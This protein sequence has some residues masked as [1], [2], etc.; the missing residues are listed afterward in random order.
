MTTSPYA[1]YKQ[2][3]PVKFSQLKCKKHWQHVIPCMFKKMLI[4]SIY[5]YV[6]SEN[7][8]IDMKHLQHN[9]KNNFS[10]AKFRYS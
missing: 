4:K 6:D 8:L 9:T 5:R 7:S 10:L 1:Y 2:E 3:I